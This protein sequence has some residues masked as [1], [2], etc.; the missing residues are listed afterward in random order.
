MDKNLYHVLGITKNASEAEIKSAYRKLARKYHPDVNKDNK[1]A[2]DKFKEISCAYDILGNKEKRKKYDNNEIDCE[3]KPTG[4]GAGGFGGG[5]PFNGGNQSY[6][7]YSGANPF[8]GGNAGGFDFSSIFGEDIFSQFGGNAGANPFGSASRR[9]RKGE[10]ISYTMRVDFLSAASGAEKSVSIQGKTIN[11]KIPAGTTDGQTLR[12]KGL[13][14]AGYNGGANGDVLITINV[15]KHPYFEENNLN[16]LL[17]LPISMKEAV[18]GAKITVP[19]ITGK[20]MV[21]IPPYSSSGEKLRLKGK[22]IKSKNGQGDQIIT[23]KI[24]APKSKNAELE[25]ALASLGDEQIRTF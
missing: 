10:D 13:G 5:N 20:V 14:H 11:V 6:Y 9:A 24:V 15:D 4:F 18:L 23:L 7:Q 17:E 22:G 12:L 21:T 2:A 25:K 1:E 16:I 19:T 8:G 3:G